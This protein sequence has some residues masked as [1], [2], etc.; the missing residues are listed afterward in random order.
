MRNTFSKLWTHNSKQISI[1]FHIND[2]LDTQYIHL[3]LVVLYVCWFSE[4]RSV[5]IYKRVCISLFSIVLADVCWH[6]SSSVFHFS[7]LLLTL[8]QPNQIKLSAVMNCKIKSSQPQHSGFFLNQA[9]K[10]LSLLLTLRLNTSVRLKLLCLLVCSFM[11]NS[12][13]IV[14]AHWNRNPTSIS[15]FSYIYGKHSLSRCIN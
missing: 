1:N 14:I 5:G 13:A 10:Q 12:L 2:Q 11:D 15:Y 8:K 4:L 9:R 7:T 6:L 3:T